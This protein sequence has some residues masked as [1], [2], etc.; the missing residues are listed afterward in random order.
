V[1]AAAGLLQA[2][3]ARISAKLAIINIERRR[4][5]IFVSPLLV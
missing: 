5:F 2:L 4:L 3:P 1:V